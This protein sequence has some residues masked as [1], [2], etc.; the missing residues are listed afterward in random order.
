VTLVV[1]HARVAAMTGAQ[2]LP[3]DEPLGLI[4]DGAVACSEGRIVYVGPSAGAPD[5]E[6][7]DAAGALLTPG[8]VDPHTH[9]VFAGDRS[10]EHA[11][12]LSGVS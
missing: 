5:G 3:G 4:E 7:I 1:K 6:V 12:R 8:F 9:L 11:L 2:P 10:Q